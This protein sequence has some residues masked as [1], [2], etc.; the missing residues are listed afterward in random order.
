MF[1]R[2]FSKISL[3]RRTFLKLW[4]FPYNFIRALDV[5]LWIFL[6]T[7]LALSLCYGFPTCWFSY[8]FYI[9]WLLLFAPLNLV[10]IEEQLSESH[11]IQLVDFE[12]HNRFHQKLFDELSI[13]EPF[14]DPIPSKPGNFIFYGLNIVSA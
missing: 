9:Y 13:A 1:L 5:F 4:V 11:L 12:V 2:P 3:N 14:S 10:E 8:F 6:L 7:E